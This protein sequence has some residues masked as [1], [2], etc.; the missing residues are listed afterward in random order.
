MSDNT[1]TRYRI[2]PIL[3][4]LSRYL[5]Y[6]EPHVHR[7]KNIQK[8]KKFMQYTLKNGL[9]SQT[10]KDWQTRQ[11]TIIIRIC[12]LKNICIICFMN[13]VTLHTC[14]TSRMVLRLRN[15]EP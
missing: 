15:F 8:E 3:Q 12:N 11:H 5:N 13:T 10:N 9:E 14:P 6:L 7:D 2:L 4:F 1:L